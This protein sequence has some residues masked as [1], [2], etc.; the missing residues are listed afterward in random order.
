MKKA[1]DAIMAANVRANTTAS[2]VIVV[3]YSAT[4]EAATQNQQ[5]IITII[6]NEH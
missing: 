2:H 5:I 1:A 3:L 6:S 4:F